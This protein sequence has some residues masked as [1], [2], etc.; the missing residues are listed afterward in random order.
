M[1]AVAR[2]AVV[3]VAKFRVLTGAKA[4]FVAKHFTYGLKARTLRGRPT[5]SL[6]KVLSTE[7]ALISVHQGFEVAVWGK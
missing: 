7:Y 3:E 2:P 6:L 1:R 5:R 4:E